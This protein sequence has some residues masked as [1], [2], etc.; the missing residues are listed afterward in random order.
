MLQ[1]ALKKKNMNAHGV[2]SKKLSNS[3][4]ETMQNN[5]KIHD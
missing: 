4:N 2:A 1:L 5:L 3:I